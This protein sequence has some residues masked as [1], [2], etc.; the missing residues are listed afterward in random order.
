MRSVPF[1][2]SVLVCT[3]VLALP[4]ED[5]WGADPNTPF[6]QNL[7]KAAEMIEA[8]LYSGALP[9]L[10]ELAEQEPGNADVFNL[11]G[12][13]YRKTGDL[14]RSAPAYERALFLNP[15]HL[16]ALEYQ[17]ELFLQLG[18]VARARANLDRLGDLCPS[19]CEEK[20]ELSA[21]IAAWRSNGSLR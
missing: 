21:A 7:A 2:M 20:E 11:L 16:G 10:K 4:A 12:F 8:E 17:G 15:D 9:L 19:S 3:S 5:H 6:A 18:D 13:A 1:L 14:N